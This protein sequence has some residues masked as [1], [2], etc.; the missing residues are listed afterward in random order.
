[1]QFGLMAHDDYDD[2][3]TDDDKDKSAV[4]QLSTVHLKFCTVLSFPSY[5]QNG[6][7]SPL[8]TPIAVRH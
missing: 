5:T 2:D 1:M 3:N 8:L 6:T 7:S 4:T